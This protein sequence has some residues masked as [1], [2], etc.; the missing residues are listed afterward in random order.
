MMLRFRLFLV[1]ALLGLLAVPAFGQSLLPAAGSSLSLSDD[2]PAAES[3]DRQFAE[4]AA[5]VALLE[6]EGNVLKRVIRLTRPT[7]VHIEARRDDEAPAVNQKPVE[8][9]GSGVVIEVGGRHYVLTNRLV[10]M[11][12]SL[13]NISIGLDDGRVLKPTQG[14]NDRETDIAVLAVA[15]KDLVA[16]RLADSSKL[17]IGDFVLAVGSPFGLSHSVTYGIIS[18]KGRRD[19][20]LGDDG[21]LYQDFLQ[22]DAAINPGNSGGPLLNLRGEV[23][24]INTAIASSSGGSEGIGFAIPINMVM[25]VA[26]QLITNG[27][28]VRAYLGVHLDSSFGPEDRREPTV[29]C[30]GGWAADRRCDPAIRQR[31]DRRRRSPG[32]PGQPDARRQTGW[33]AG[34]A[35]RAARASEGERWQPGRYEAPDRGSAHPALG[36]TLSLSRP[37][38]LRG[39]AS[40][41]RS[42][43]CAVSWEAADLAGRVETN[44]AE[45]RFVRYDAERRNEDGVAKTAAMLTA[46]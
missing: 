41:G 19:L 2:P 30:R 14:W 9:A 5:E 10:I 24:G 3:R 45:R 26:Q 34:D 1:A 46:Y 22:T 35:R 39:N 17:E 13:H 43:S 21:V 23:V 28:V 25:T 8:E 42:A 16:A 29:A 40:H 37:H 38:A 4:L 15:A 36:P 27:S 7:V 20:Q 6:R 44:D 12:S 31:A 11:H 32:E 33:S 18:A